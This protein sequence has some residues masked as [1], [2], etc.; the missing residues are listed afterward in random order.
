MHKKLCFCH[1]IH[2]ILCDLFL[3]YYKVRCHACVGGTS[4]HEDMRILQSGVHVV[5]G[6]P[7][8]VFDMLRRRAL[9]ADFIKIFCLDEADE[10]LSRGKS[11][12]HTSY[13]LCNY[14]FQG[15]NI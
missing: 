12:I 2:Y 1:T 14:R 5:V 13:I 9:R 3:S 10:M 8:R 15:S 6:T 7:G 4:V 11:F